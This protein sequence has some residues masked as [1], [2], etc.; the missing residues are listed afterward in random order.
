MFCPKCATQ[1]VE[2]ASYCRICGS[3]ISLV[4]QAL[5]GQ[6]ANQ[7]EEARYDDRQ[8][9]R[10]AASR[11]RAIRS[12]LM[13]VVFATMLALTSAFSTGKTHWYFWL[14][15]PAMLMFSRGFAELI[16]LQVRSRRHTA[17]QSPLS[18]ARPLDLSAAKTGELITAA[19]SVTEGTTR[20]LENEPGTR[21]R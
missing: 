19:P 4:P 16:R 12:L 5:S 11:D 6:L 8:L 17:L 15:L 2:G 13:G 7:Q 20:L 10:R 18:S 1:N 21:Q 14:L 9:S 3:N